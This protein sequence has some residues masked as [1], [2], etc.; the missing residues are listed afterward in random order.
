MRAMVAGARTLLLP[1][2]EEESGMPV[3]EALAIG[4]PASIAE[5]AA[6]RDVR[7][8]VPNYLNPLNGSGW[9]GATR[10]YARPDPTRPDP[11][12]RTAQRRAAN[13]RV[14]RW[15]DYMRIVLN[16]IDPL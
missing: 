6:L 7:R 8:Q 1:F 2:F 13:W 11:P 16:L 5:I 14:W 9:R 10:D 4:T 3:A 12:R 15:S